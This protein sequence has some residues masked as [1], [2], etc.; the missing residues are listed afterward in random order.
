[1]LAHF[2]QGKG[3]K[4]FAPDVLDAKGCETLACERTISRQDRVGEGFDELKIRV[5]HLDSTEAEVGGVDKR[6]I[7]A[8]TNS[9]PLV[10]WPSIG[11]GVI[12]LQ[13]GIG[14]VDIGVPTRNRAVFSSKDEHTWAG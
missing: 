5:V 6:V 9:K 7:L 11:V 8:L 13:D 2:L 4:E 10:D 14:R 1:M 3:D 12:H